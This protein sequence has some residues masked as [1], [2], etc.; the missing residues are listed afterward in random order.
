MTDVLNIPIPFKN[1]VEK[2]KIN[3]LKVTNEVKLLAA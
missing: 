2:N 3:K 1:M